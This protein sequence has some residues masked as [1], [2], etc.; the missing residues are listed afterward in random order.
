MAICYLCGIKLIKNK[1][2][3]K[4]HVPPDC[5]FP[6]KKPLNLITV[7]C[8]TKCNGKFKELDE[9]MRNYFAILAGDKSKDLGKISTRVLFR[10]NKKMVEFISNT[11]LHH[12]LKDKNG[13]PRLL[14]YFDK[15]EI[16]PWL[17]RLVKGIYFKKNKIRLEN[18]GF[19]V[20]QYPDIKTPSCKSFHYEE[21]LEYCPYFVYKMF[22]D[23]KNI[24]LTHWVFMFYDHL[25][26]QVTVNN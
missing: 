4:D 3:S 11:R 8:C 12:S 19:S 9:K 6:V 17:I 15:N 2:K 20:K 21:G 24:N 22:T 25:I 26:F 23:D 13:Y 5:I 7:Q 14:Y 1:N 10:N 16:D 18:V